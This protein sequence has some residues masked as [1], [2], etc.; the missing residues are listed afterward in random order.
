[1]SKPSVIDPAYFRALVTRRLAEAGGGPGPGRSLAP[2]RR[3]V[4]GAV[5]EVRDDAGEDVGED[6]AE[7]GASPGGESESSGTLIVGHAAVF[8]SWTTLYESKTYVWR[9]IVRPGA[10]A[11]AVKEAQDVRFLF[12]HDPNYVVGRST[13]GTCRYSEDAT[14]LYCE[15]DDPQTQTI[16]DLVVKPMK[17][18]D[19]TQMS[20]AFRVRPGG[21]KVT[22]TEVDGQ[23]IE[24]RELTDLDLFD[25]SIVTYP[26]YEDTDC[27]CVERGRQRD[28]EM[29]EILASRGRRGDS[30]R[31]LSRDGR[32]R[33]LAL[34]DLRIRLVG[35]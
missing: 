33:A 2:S 5:A 30:L 16:T 19:L 3:T 34:L 8:D 26:A 29:R 25:V 35:K 32:A 10:F 9:E 20:F 22:I 21:E 24:E 23:I 18:G 17:R 14:G 7:G 4:A 1:V 31:V 13:S 6:Q 15:A 27:D 12:N 11:N 28:A